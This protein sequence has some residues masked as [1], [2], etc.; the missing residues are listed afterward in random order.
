LLKISG[1]LATEDTTQRADGQK[2]AFGTGN[3]S[4]AIGSETASRNNVVYV[5]MMVKVL[6]PGVE[7]S[8]E[9]DVCSQMLRVASQFE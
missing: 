4:G 8:K 6:A 1:E 7:H 9:S 2:E 5:W 3:P